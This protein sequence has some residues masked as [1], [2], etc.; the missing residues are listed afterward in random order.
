M[1]PPA[2]LRLDRVSSPIGE[3]LLVTDETGAVRALDFH[4]YIPRMSRLLRLH[5]GDLSPETGAAPA[6]VRAALNAYFEGVLDALSAVAWATN[7]T[8]FQRQV[9]S[10]LLDVPAGTTSTYAALAAR[11]EK[12][13]ATRAVGAA[14]GANPIAILVPCHRLVGATGALTGYGGGLERKAWLLR[15]EGARP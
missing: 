5:Y 13:A 8:A 3:I 11:I 15:H 10:A 4:D 6:G 2:R 14:N 7:G 12:P 9:W 1:S